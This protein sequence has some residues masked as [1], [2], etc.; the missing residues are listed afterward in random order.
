[1]NGRDDNA[2][3]YL[4]VWAK[5]VGFSLEPHLQGF[6]LVPENGEPIIVETFADVGLELRRLTRRIL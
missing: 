6:R 1:L 2:F 5:A 4:S 3:Q